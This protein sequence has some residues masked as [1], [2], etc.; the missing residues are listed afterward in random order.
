MKIRSN[1]AS[2]Y[3]QLDYAVF[4]G[5]QYIDTRVSGNNGNLDIIC[6][7]EPNTT[8]QQCIFAARANSS[9]GISFWTDGYCHFGNSSSQVA[10]VSSSGK[11]TVRLNKTGLYFDGTK[12]NFTP[13]TSFQNANLV[14]GRIPGDDRA[15][16]GKIHRVTV[17]DSTTLVRDFVSAKRASDNAIGY[18]ETTNKT[19]YTISGSGALS[20]GTETD[21]Y[22]K[23]DYF[24]IKSV[25]GQDNKQAQ[26]FKVRS[27]FLPYQYQKLNYI[28]R[29]SGEAYI[30]TG[31]IPNYTDGFD[32]EFEFRPLTSGQRYCLAANY[33]QGNKQ[34]SLEINASNQTRYWCNSNDLM[35]GGTVKTSSINTAKF[36]FYN[37][38]CTMVCNGVS[39]TKALSV[40]GASDYSLW[41]FLDRAKRT[42]TYTN[43]LEIY[44]FKVYS[45]GK[46]I[47]NLV[48][49][50][51]KSDSVIGFYDTVKHVFLDK[52]GSGELEA[53]PE[54]NII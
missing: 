41:L 40:S 28:K 32:I 35:K 42:T 36:S 26:A 27:L 31:Y 19:F 39:A 52:Q 17:Y 20:A 5:T 16:T 49:C 18:Y 37:N 11:H 14:F 50:K 7:Y 9:G 45:N 22:F 13:G 6:T 2:A 33:N 47:H 44:S 38:I 43:A 24:N 46:I 25:I 8:N 48:P 53:G 23:T 30:D 10:G 4:S 1:L 51:R 3:Q 34:L 15:F 29:T 54:I 21:E 12:L